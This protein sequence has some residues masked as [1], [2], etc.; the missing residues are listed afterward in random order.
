MTHRKLP[1]FRQNFPLASSWDQDTHHPHHPPLCVPWASPSP[2]FW[3][4]GMSVSLG[5]TQPQDQEAQKGHLWT[6]ATQNSGGRETA[7]D[8]GGFLRV[9][10]RTPICPSVCLEQPAAGEGLEA[11]NMGAGLHLRVCWLSG[12]GQVKPSELHVVYMFN[13]S[14]SCSTWFKVKI[15]DKQTVSWKL[16]CKL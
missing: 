10:G 13:E 4:S 8:E 7:G 6:P 15:R 14:Q 12:L 16:L 11:E 1:L 2:M 3:P 9:S 5:T